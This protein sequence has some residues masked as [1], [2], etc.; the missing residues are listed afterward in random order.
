MKT[1]HTA[2]KNTVVLSVL[3]LTLLACSSDDN[4]NYTIAPPETIPK[5]ADLNHYDNGRRVMMQAFYWDVEP[6][7]EWWN[8]L[9][10]KVEDWAATGVDRIWLPV[11]TKG[12]SGGYS[13]GYDPSDYFDFGEFDQHGTIPTRFGT[14]E[15]LENL[16]Q[17]RRDAAP[18]LA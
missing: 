11:A 4:N 1:P 16:I 6:R 17:K 10:E 7:F 13:M 14:R 15:Q 8:T 12:Q 9:S 18:C 3:I 5:K 2:L